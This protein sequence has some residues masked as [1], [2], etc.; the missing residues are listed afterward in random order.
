MAPNVMWKNGRNIAP[1]T[2]VSSCCLGRQEGTQRRDSTI[3]KN[4]QDSLFQILFNGFYPERYL[5][6]P[7][8]HR[9][10][11]VWLFT[12]DSKGPWYVQTSN[13]GEAKPWHSHLG[14]LYAREHCPAC[15]WAYLTTRILPQYDL[16]IP[17]SSCLCM[18]WG[19]YLLVFENSTKSLD[20]FLHKCQR[21]KQVEIWT[22]SID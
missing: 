13:F 12:S 7:R 16:D 1:A 9:L 5:E 10:F 17:Y 8:F 20:L 15:Q 14:G 19:K 3:E 22:H 18:F 21:P 2:A 6:V 4:C 11:M